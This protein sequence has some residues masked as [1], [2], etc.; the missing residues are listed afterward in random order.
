M[1]ATRA[2]KGLNLPLFAADSVASPAIT[3]VAPDRVEADQIQAIVK[4]NLTLP[5][6]GQDHQKIK[7][8]RIGHL[9][10]LRSRYLEIDSSG[11]SL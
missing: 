3:A 8:F 2:I 9:F 7:I 10:C 11:S 6:L 5:R 4:S 1:N